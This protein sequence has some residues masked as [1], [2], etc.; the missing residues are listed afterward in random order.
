M[1]FAGLSRFRSVS[2]Q[3]EGILPAM[4]FCIGVDDNP[5]KYYLYCTCS[6]IIT[7]H[8]LAI[9]CYQV[10]AQETT[11]FFWF[12]FAFEL[13]DVTVLLCDSDKYTYCLEV[14]WRYCSQFSSQCTDK[15]IGAL[16]NIFVH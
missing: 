2:S 13:C 9:M 5:T 10:Y 8:V 14:D 16:E 1:L 6:I 11:E 7:M 3:T 4:L 12:F 15:Y